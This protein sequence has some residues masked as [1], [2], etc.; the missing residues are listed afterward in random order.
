M[1]AEAAEEAAT[2]VKAELEEEAEPEEEVNILNSLELCFIRL[3]VLHLVV[4]IQT[5]KV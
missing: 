5:V 1:A 2:A 3:L 4:T